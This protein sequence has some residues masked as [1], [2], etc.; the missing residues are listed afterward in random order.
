MYMEDE[1]DSCSTSTN[2]Q[3]SCNLISLKNLVRNIIATA[4][5]LVALTR[6]IHNR[7]KIKWKYSGQE[8]K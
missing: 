3:Q 4:D 1:M 2:I 6:A 5:L 8:G 7:S